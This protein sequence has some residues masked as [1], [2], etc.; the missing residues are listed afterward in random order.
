MIMDNPNWNW[1]CRCN[2]KIGE[3]KAP[4]SHC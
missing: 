4:Q 1:N 3:P 2:S